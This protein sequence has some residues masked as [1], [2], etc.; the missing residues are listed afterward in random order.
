MAQNI[1]L[2]ASY[3]TIAGRALPHTD[4]DYRPFGFR[5]RVESAAKAGFKGIGIWHTDLAHT[6][7]KHLE[8]E[9]LTGW[10][11]DGDEKKQSD[12]Q[13]KNLLTA[14]EALGARHIKVGDLFSAENSDAAPGRVIPRAVPGRRGSWDENS[15]RADALRDDRYT[16]GRFGHGRRRGARNGGIIFDLWHLVKL[17]IPYEWKDCAIILL[18]N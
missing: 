7:E 2:L 1:E 17:R 14:A 11:S 6:L 9:F 3:W 12:I 18:R 10:F 13:K 5:D 16:L 4:K 8:L 15:F